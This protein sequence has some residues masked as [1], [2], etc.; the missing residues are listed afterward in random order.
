MRNKIGLFLVGVLQVIAANA[1]VIQQTPIS[2]SPKPNIILAYDDSG[3]MAD[4]TIPDNPSPSYTSTDPAAKSYWYNALAYNPA[5]TYTPWVKTKTSTGLTYYPDAPL[6]TV[7]SF[8]VD[9]SGAITSG[10]TVASGSLYQVT[11]TCNS[12]SPGKY[13][14]SYDYDT[15]SVFTSRT[16]CQN[17]SGTTY[18]VASSYTA[19]TGQSWQRGTMASNATYYTLVAS[20]ACTLSG[21]SCVTAPVCTTSSTCGVT[22]S[23]AKLQQVTIAVDD[24]ANL[25]NYANWLMYANSRKNM[26]AFA[27]SKVIPSLTGVIIGFQPYNSSSTSNA[28]TRAVDS[29][30]SS[31]TYAGTTYYA[32]SGRMYNMDL[33]SD[34]TTLLDLIYNT[35][36]GSATPTRTTLLKIGGIFANKTLAYSSYANDG[37]AVSN[38]KGVV[39]YACQKNAAFVLTDGYTNESPS[40]TMPAYD[41]GKTDQTYATKRPYWNTATSKSQFSTSLADIA[42]RY[43]TNNIRNDLSTGQVPADTYSTV[44][45]DGNTNLHMNTYALTLGAT[46]AIYGTNTYATQTAD[47][48]TNVPTFVDPTGTTNNTKQIDDLWHSTINGRGMMFQASGDPT[49]LV[50]QIEN[51]IMHVILSAGTRASIAVANKYMDAS[52]NAVYIPTYYLD[53]NGNY[54]GDVKKY[55]VTLATQTLDIANADWSASAK[56]NAVTTPDTTR[57]IVTYSGTEGASFSATTTGLAATLVSYV[58][59]DKSI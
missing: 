42:L 32:S 48:F 1:T 7:K 44:N 43:Y 27:M 55:T 35:E 3:S 33:P 59:G 6:S 30:V 23:G 20:S 17:K 52:N 29:S 51:G 56:L 34:V 57:K 49:N 8:T 10:G 11:Y 31:T 38:S 54:L 21:T 18:T 53:A 4:T 47:P 2:L 12:N 5:V 14:T 24:T 36:S 9:S 46:G 16:T 39:Q 40:L 58:R 45:A 50:K 41:S 15:G 26:V 19:K 22:A 37:T 28:N 25:Q 13:N